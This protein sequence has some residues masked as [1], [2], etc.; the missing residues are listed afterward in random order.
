VTVEPATDQYVYLFVMHL[1]TL[2]VTQAIVHIISNDWVIMNEDVE[3][4]G[5]GLIYGTI[6]E[7]TWTDL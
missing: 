6:P 5:R 3:G 2:P 1:T 4:S 7:F